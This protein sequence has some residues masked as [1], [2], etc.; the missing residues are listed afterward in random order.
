M[1]FELDNSTMVRFEKESYHFS[2]IQDGQTV[3][4]DRKNVKE[5]V[6]LFE[7]QGFLD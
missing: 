2:I 5:L 1:R 7:S 6:K 4:L 3:F